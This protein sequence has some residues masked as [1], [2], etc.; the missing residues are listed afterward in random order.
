MYCTQTDILLQIDQTTLMNLTDDTGSE[1]VDSDILTRAIDD[2]DATIDSYI[3]AVYATPL[4]VVPDT[5]RKLSV[6]MSIYNL[7]ARRS[8]TLPDVRKDRQSA[9]IKMLIRIADNTISLS[10]ATLTDVDA[11]VTTDPVD[12]IFSMGKA[13]DNSAGT[14][15]D[16]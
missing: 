5:I 3:S 4:V 12:R 11:A 14:L 1:I 10:V 8:D 6:D 16:Y 2:A 13:S 7:Y 15:D 9:A